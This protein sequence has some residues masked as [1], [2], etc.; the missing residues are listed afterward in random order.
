MI[1]RASVL[2]YR[3]LYPKGFRLLKVVGSSQVT[4]R[5]EAARARRE[6][7]RAK[8]RALKNKHTLD[9][10]VSGLQHMYFK[11]LHTTACDKL[12]ALCELWERKTVT[13]EQDASSP[14]SEEG[15]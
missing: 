5:Q 11:Q 2:L 4:E 6:A 15:M 8:L 12:V 13:L 9:T 14:A 10:E 3:Y 1:C 7:Q